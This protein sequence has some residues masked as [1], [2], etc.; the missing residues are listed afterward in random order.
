MKL[1]LLF[2]VY[3][4]CRLPSLPAYEALYFPVLRRRVVPLLASDLDEDSC[5]LPIPC[6]EPGQ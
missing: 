6:M 4:Q 3:L 5:W 2:L 1:V